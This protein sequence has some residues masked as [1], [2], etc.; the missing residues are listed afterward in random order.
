MTKEN[1]KR[2]EKNNKYKPLITLFFVQERNYDTYLHVLN[3]SN[4]KVRVSVTFVLV[5]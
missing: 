1:K 2:L 4:Y 3:I 5:E